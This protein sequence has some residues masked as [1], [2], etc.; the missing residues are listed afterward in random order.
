M[1]IAV[2]GAGRTEKS[3]QIEMLARRLNAIVIAGSAPVPGLFDEI[4]R[5]ALRKLST[6]HLAGIS[7]ADISS[8]RIGELLFELKEGG[9]KANILL[10]S[11]PNADEIVELEQV[12]KAARVQIDMLIYL[13]N[14]SVSENDRAVA[15]YYADRTFI[16]QVRTNGR[17]VEDVADEI[18]SAVRA[19]FREIGPPPE[20]TAFI[21]IKEAGFPKRLRLA[22]TAQGYEFLGD[23]ATET[24]REVSRIP[25]VGRLAV[26][27]IRDRLVRSGLNFGMEISGFPRERSENTA[28]YGEVLRR[29]Q[30]AEQLD[31]GAKF[32]AGDERLEISIEIAPSDQEAAS[33]SITEQF[34]EEALRKLRKF[35]SYARRLDNQPGWNGIEGLCTRFIEILDRP[36]SGIPEVIGLIY[37][38]SLEFGSYLE[39]DTKIRAGEPSYAEK[40][41]PEVRRA[42]EDFVMTAAPWVR[43]FPS[44]RESDDQ[45]SNYLSQTSL[46]PAA[47]Q[48][49]Q[50]AAKES[51]ISE[52][53]AGVLIEL[54]RTATREGALSNKA[55]KRGVF[56]VR[57][58]VLM[59]G[60]TASSL[61]VGALGSDI[62]TKSALI[63]SAGTFVTSAEK[64]IMELLAE[65][66][67]DLRL[68]FELLIKNIPGDPVV[69]PP[70][71]IVPRR[72]S[73]SKNSKDADR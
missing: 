19:R 60:A 21:S 15:R 35:E 14:I 45:L 8:K 49:V 16:A 63:Q 56:S 27:L 10:D 38:G 2:I 32:E 54:L 4:N 69:L 17:A 3:R 24:T 71:V 72:P 43:R 42:L 36:T 46:A 62:A 20:E 48:A 73:K 23:L 40:L 18:W 70:P 64:P 7:S 41:E 37:S 39:Q 59:A 9:A 53:T 6:T 44:A 31:V 25:G 29:L 50:Q 26:E 13:R 34:H 67:S 58:L 66:P 30:S 22:L 47:T 61:V 65:M 68:A 52:D 51:L 57:N 33:N 5:E 1:I 12:L 11:F 28:Y 55:T